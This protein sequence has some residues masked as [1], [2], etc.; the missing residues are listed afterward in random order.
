ALIWFFG[1]AERPEGPLEGQAPS[2][3]TSVIDN[4]ESKFIL[5]HCRLSR[6]LLGSLTMLAIKMTFRV[7]QLSEDGIG[8]ESPEKIAPLGEVLFQEMRCFFGV[9]PP[10]DV[11]NDT[12][13]EGEI[14]NGKNLMFRW[15]PF[16]LS[17][18]E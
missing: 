12:L 8:A 7:T 10:L 1:A 16:E 11:L 15:R 3:R 6:R 4:P 14:V 9:L 2:R 17:M 5:L 13:R 18:P